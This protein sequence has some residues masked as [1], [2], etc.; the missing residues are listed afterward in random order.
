MLTVSEYGW[1]WRICRL[2]MVLTNNVLGK[3]VSAD[4]LV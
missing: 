3:V 2:E 4:V 1:G